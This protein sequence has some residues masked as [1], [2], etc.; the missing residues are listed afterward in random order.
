[1]IFLNG[2][3]KKHLNIIL[4]RF[5]PWLLRE[6]KMSQCK[7]YIHFFKWNYTILLYSMISL[8]THKEIKIKI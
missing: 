1:M 8:I 5:K 4:A 7:N 3:I 6:I 2:R